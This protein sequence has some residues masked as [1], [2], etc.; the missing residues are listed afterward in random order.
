MQRIDVPAGAS[1]W[2]QQRGA[3]ELSRAWLAG[4]TFV[5]VGAVSEAS[6]TLTDVTIV[7]VAAS[8]CG[9]MPCDPYGGGFGLSAHFGASLRA[10]RFDV[11]DVALCGVVVGGDIGVPTSVDLDTG[12]IAGAPV[13]ACVQVD[14]YDVSRLRRDVQYG[15]VGLPTQ[16]TRYTLPDAL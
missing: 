13:G 12:T 10:T 9:G 8:D 1:A 6:V 15:D 5:G 14:G 3:L 7:D 2:A 4:S 16:A 11:R